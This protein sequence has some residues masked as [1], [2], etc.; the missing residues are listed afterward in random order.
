MCIAVPGEIIDLFP[1]QARVK[2]MGVETT[3]NIQ[4]IESPKIG[5]YVLVHG[6][7]AIEKINRAY[8][9][10]LFNIFISITDED[11]KK[12]G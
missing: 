10:D 11:E 9:D 5:E 4:L 12:D 2:L 8:F 3:I 6:G 1:P 7:C